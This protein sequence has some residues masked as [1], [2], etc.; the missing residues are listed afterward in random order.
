MK[1]LVKKFFLL[2]GMTFSRLMAAGIKQFHNINELS[3]RLIV[4]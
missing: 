3:K 2:S 1:N 4:L